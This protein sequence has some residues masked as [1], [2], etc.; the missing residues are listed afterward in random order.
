LDQL[1]FI[2]KLLFTCLTKQA[3][4]IRRS[5]VLSLLLSVR[6]PWLQLRLDNLFNE[7]ANAALDA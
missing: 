5:N 7:L 1:I 6:V 4:V 3:T 2:L